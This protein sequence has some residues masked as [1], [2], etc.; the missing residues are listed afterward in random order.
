MYSPHPPNKPSMAL[1]LAAFLA[2]FLA[3]FIFLKILLLECH[4]PNVLKT[5]SF[6]SQPLKLF[7]S[8]IRFHWREKAQAPAFTKLHLARNKAIQNY[9]LTAKLGHVLPRKGTL[10]KKSAF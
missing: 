10:Q 9:S 6:L 5:L 1:A 4:F 7:H 2:I 8:T 3:F